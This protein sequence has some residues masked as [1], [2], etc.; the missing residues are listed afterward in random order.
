MSGSVTFCFQCVHFHRVEV[1][2]GGEVEQLA[3]FVLARRL[4]DGE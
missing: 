4:V 1:E 3:A 2:H